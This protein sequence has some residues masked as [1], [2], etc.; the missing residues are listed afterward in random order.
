MDFNELIEKIKRPLMSF[1]GFAYV[2]LG[3]YVINKQWFLT[4]LDP[5]FAYGLGLVLIAYG[6]FRVFRAVKS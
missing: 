3:I 1:I 6:A 2:L 5:I 4:K